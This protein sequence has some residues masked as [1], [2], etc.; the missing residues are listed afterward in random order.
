MNYE[1]VVKARLLKLETFEFNGV[2]YYKARLMD[3]GDIV[4]MSVKND[5]KLT[6]EIVS[7]AK[8]EDESDHEFTIA[9]T[10]DRTLK[11]KVQI[12]AFR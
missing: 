12:V 3:K 7:V 11:P 5:P 8:E 1:I 6:A 2:T 4:D 10:S 9:L